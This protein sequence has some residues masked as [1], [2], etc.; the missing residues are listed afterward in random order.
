M[1]SLGCY[2]GEYSPLRS[3]ALKHTH[4]RSFSCVAETYSLQR[5]VRGNSFQQKNANFYKT[6]GLFFGIDQPPRAGWHSGQHSRLVFMRCLVRISSGTPVSLKYFV[7][8]LSSSRK[9]TGQYLDYDTT[10]SF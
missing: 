4:T 6:F 8:V 5:E 1:T 9:M 3:R 10:A 2:P 7:V